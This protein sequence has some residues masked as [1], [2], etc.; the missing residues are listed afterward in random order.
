MAYLGAS[1]LAS[2]ASPSKD[3]F[4]GDNST[5][6]FTMGQSVGDPNQI[7]VFVDTCATSIFQINNNQIEIYPNPADQYIH[8][9][10]DGLKEI[11]TILGEKLLV[12]YENNI[13][14]SNLSKGV[15]LI[16]LK[17]TTIRLIKN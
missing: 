2:F 14:I 5:T 10:Y 11:Y 4:S 15:Y 3:T 12:T 9:N 17:N 7:E 6:A 1:P 8:I 16:K 13:N